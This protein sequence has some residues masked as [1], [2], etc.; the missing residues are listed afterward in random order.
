MYH[1]SCLPRPIWS[2]TLEKVEALQ[3]ASHEQ[4]LRVTH[5]AATSAKAM[6]TEDL[7]EFVAVR[8]THSQLLPTFSLRT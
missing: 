4:S 3:Q 6:W 5:L 2:L 7:D 8:G 1:L